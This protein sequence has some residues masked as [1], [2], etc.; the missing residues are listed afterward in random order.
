MTHSGLVTPHSRPGT[1]SG[2]ATT[3][4]T[5]T[6]TTTN[7]AN[8]PD[9]QHASQPSLTPLSAST[10]AQS[11]SRPPSAA[12][13]A[14]GSSS[15][16]KPSVPSYER[17]IY[18]RFMGLYKSL[19]EIKNNR[20][21]YIDS[22]QV[23]S[24]YDTFLDAINELKL[25]RK[26]EELKGMKLDLPNSNDSIIDD[27][28]QLLSLCFVTCGLIKFAPATYSSLSTVMKLLTHLKECKVYTM[29]DLEPVGQ[30]LSEISEII[31]SSQDKYAADDDEEEDG[32]RGG[33]LSQN[34]QIEENLLRNKLIK[35]ENL[36]KELV[37][38]FENIPHDLEPIYHELIDLRHQLLNFVTDFG[39]GDDEENTNDETKRNQLKDKLSQYKNE[40]K[41]IEKLRDESD[42]KFHSDEVEDE[43]KLDSIQAVLN[44]LIDDCNNLIS[45]LL[46]HDEAYALKSLEIDDETTPNPELKNQYDHVYKN[47]QDMKSTLENIL[48]TRRWTLRETDLYNYQ[49]TLKTIDDSRINIFSQTPKG[50]YKK[51]QTLI[52]Y[53]LR[54]CYSIVYKL[55]ESSEP[56]SESLA[57]IHNQLQTVKRCLLELKRV[58]GLNNL[59]EL[60]PFQFKL[61]SI[62]NLRKDGKFIIHQTVPEGQGAVCALL[63]ECF[64]I[65]QEM[66]IDLEEKELEEEEEEE[67][68]EEEE[69]QGT[70]GQLNGDDKEGAGTNDPNQANTNG[71]ASSSQIPEKI[72][73][74]GSF[75]NSKAPGESGIGTN[76]DEL[77]DVELKRNRFKEFNEA[78][79]DVESESAF[80]GDDDD[81]SI[82]DSEVE[83]NDYY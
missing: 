66:K 64:D 9:Q 45:D 37:D 62:D 13:T 38:N 56:V 20:N 7:T 25:T 48:L 21:K 35:C 80:G 17:S 78:D 49:K 19:L 1:P 60:Y 65:L 16:N 26:D 6:T 52:L 18:E 31:L 69:T 70:T 57:P 47:L 22:K 39:Q 43:Q 71:V 41:Q 82:T 53:L 33:K 81:L 34:H 24:I 14:T 59:R 8:A 15:A 55:L 23:Y 29:A 77:D 42:G 4:I 3:T 28:F 36:F 2:L 75:T 11:I 5:P 10:Q 67:E 63:S 73:I 50:K 46:I 54:K 51:Y 79:Y 76:S 61:A 44:G 27:I 40:L 83:G 74:S 68:G 12:A 32:D 72:A 30:R 58:D